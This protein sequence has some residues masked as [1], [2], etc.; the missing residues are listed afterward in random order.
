MKKPLFAI[1]ALMLCC[2]LTA[3]SSATE[4]PEVIGKTAKE[5]SQMLNDA[6][7][8]SSNVE[9][10]DEEGNKIY[11]LALYEDWLVEDQAP[12]AG[13]EIDTSSS[14]NKVVVTILN[15]STTPVDGSNIYTLVEEYNSTTESLVFIE[16]FIPSDKTSKHYRTEFRLGAY[17]NAAG[18]SYSYDDASVDIVESKSILGE[19]DIRIYMDN[20]T[21]DQVINVVKNASPIL[22]KNLT[23]NELQETIEYITQHKEANGY[24]FGDLG[25]VLTG[26]DAKGYQLMLKTD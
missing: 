26:N 18:K 11:S 2:V 16:D 22:D 15:P 19:I 13:E 25:L 23:T 21:L 7:I 20:A 8:R 3:C 5:A 4:V 17:D 6:G 9:Y 12:Q 1:C 14:K 10:I 24:Y